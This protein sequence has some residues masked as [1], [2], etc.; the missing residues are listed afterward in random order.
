VPKLTQLPEIRDARIRLRYP[1]DGISW[2]L[3]ELDA[4]PIDYG[5]PA[6][7]TAD[8]VVD[9]HEPRLQGSLQLSAELQAAAEQMRISGLQLLGSDLAVGEGEGLALALTADLDLRV[10]DSAWRVAD[11]QIDSGALH[12]QAELSGR[13]AE[14]GPEMSG[15]FRLQGFDLPRTPRCAAPRRGDVSRSAG[16]L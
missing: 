8:L 11:L 6:S 2:S 12:L 14:N 4:G 1:G 7:L 13:S 3:F 16:R 5:G 10:T 9:G 15:S